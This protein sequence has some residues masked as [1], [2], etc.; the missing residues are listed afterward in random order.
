MSQHDFTV[1]A[2]ETFQPVFQ[3]GSTTLTSIP[4]TGITQAAPAVVTAPG[5]GVP[6]D[7]EVAVA[8]AKGM[9]QINAVGYPPRG[10]DWH[11]ATVLTDDTLAL[12]DMNSAD[13]SAYASGGFLVYGT[14]VDLTSVTA[15]MTIRD[16]PSDGAVL[17]ELVSGTGIV[18]DTAAK[19][20]TA[21]IETAALTWASGYYGLLVSDA[22]TGKTTQ[23][24]EGW[25]FIL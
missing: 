12:R 1:G 5:H 7:W 25:V 18:I 14:P 21:T 8:S 19:T 3:W 15:V 10:R 6:P 11:R 22:S 4:I 2:G 17:L 16:A 9:T 13:F 20:I 24:A 23:L